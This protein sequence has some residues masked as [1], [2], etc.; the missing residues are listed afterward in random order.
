M[1]G[2]YGGICGGTERGG[3]EAIP[4]SAFAMASRWSITLVLR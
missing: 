3:G 4:I 1:G 2:L